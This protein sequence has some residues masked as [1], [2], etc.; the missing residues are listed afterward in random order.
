MGIYIKKNVKDKAF[1]D[2]EFNIVN[3]NKPE[4]ISIG[5]VI[6]SNG[7]RIIDSFYSLVKPTENIILTNE[8]K[9]ITHITQIEINKAPSLKKVLKEFMKWIYQYFRAK[10]SVYNWGVYDRIAMRRILYVID[11]SYIYTMFFDYIID[12]QPFISKNIIYKGVYIS[13]ELGLQTMKEIYGI[14]GDV[15]HNALD[16][17]IDLMKVVDAFYCNKKINTDIL[18]TLYIKEYESK[19][20]LDLNID[21]KVTNPSLEFI[22]T[23][24]DLGKILVADNGDAFSV[25]DN[26]IAISDLEK[27]NHKNA[28][29]YFK[30]IHEFNPIFILKFEKGTILKEYIFTVSKDNRKYI[31]RFLKNNFCNNIINTEMVG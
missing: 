1:I 19:A 6:V 17:S 11:D 30:L 21:L 18:E 28:N 3:R 10:V 25:T 12:I 8:C 31:R 7:N 15:K 29:F 5:C 2:F 16:D 14:K 20:M 22:S 23:L 4:L 9:A 27:I 13:K 24:A 26:Y